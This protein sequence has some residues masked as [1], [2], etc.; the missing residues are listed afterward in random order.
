MDEYEQAVAVAEKWR[1][2]QDDERRRNTGVVR[3]WAGQVYGW[4][5]EL[6]RAST[7][8]PGALAVGARGSVWVAVGGNAENGAQ[9]WDEVGGSDDGSPQLAAGTGR[10]ITADLHRE[11][12]DD[13]VSSADFFAAARKIH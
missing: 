7:E 9:S 3:V 12:G 11:L 2:S 5:G 8:R 10:D 13:P 4:A 6:G 1:R